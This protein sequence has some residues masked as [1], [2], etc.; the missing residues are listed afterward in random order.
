MCEAEPDRSQAR[1]CTNKAGRLSS[2]FM[3][4]YDCEYSKEKESR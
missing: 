2:Y 4:D 1:T 3:L